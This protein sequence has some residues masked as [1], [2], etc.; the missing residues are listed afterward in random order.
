MADT[1]KRK[2]LEKMPNEPVTSS[3]SPTFYCHRCGRAFSR[4]KGYFPVSHSPMYRGVGYLPWCNDCI[5]EMYEECRVEFGD[6]KEAMRRMCMKTDLYWSE[7]IYNMVERSAGINSRIR[8]YV[9]KA[10]LVRFIDKTFDDTLKEEASIKAPQSNIEP[11]IC[12]DFD[13]N[14][15]ST[16]EPVDPAL[17]DFWGSG[18]PAD[19]YAEL[20]RKY[21]EWTQGLTNMSQ[22]ERALYKQIC[23]SEV[24]ISRDAANG[25]PIKDNQKQLNEL[26][27]S[28]NL[29]PSQQKTDADAELEKMPLGVGIEKWE[30]K[31]PLPETDENLRDVNHRVRDITTWY[32]G[33]GA[34][35]VNLRGAHVQMYDDAMDE[36]RVKFPEYEDEDDDTMLTDIFGNSKVGGKDE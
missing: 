29:R 24:I 10:N 11:V 17:I 26:L 28:M 9:G 20:E 23:L 3:S 35:M 2:R 27:G 36:L 18:Y 4:R 1:A 31:R 22:S 8:T 25:L 15:I 32:L 13:N 12:D 6:D 5:D 14:E 7:S 16:E 21:S 19:F 34:K 33:H 30:S